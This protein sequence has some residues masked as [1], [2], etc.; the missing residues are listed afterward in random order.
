M[1]E[2]EFS[3]FVSNHQVVLLD[4]GWGHQLL[5]YGTPC[6]DYLNIV[7]P[8]AVKKIAES[9]LRAGSAIIGTN[10][11]GANRIRLSDLDLD[12]HAREINRRG[13]DIS[14][15]AAAGK[16]LVAGTI[17]PAVSVWNISLSNRLYDCFAE[18]AMFLSDAGVDLLCLETMQDIRQLEIALVASY[19]ACGLPVLC[20]VSPPRGERE[21]RSG[22]V[23]A[24]CEFAVRHCVVAFGV[25]CGES[26]DD[27]LPFIEPLRSV[28]PETPILFKPSAGV[29]E[30]IDGQWRYPIKPEP[31]AQYIR[32]AVNAGAK[33]VGGCCGT[34]ASYIEETRTILNDIN[35]EES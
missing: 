19:E 13:A 29:P 9:F 7:N 30:K 11:F 31:F 35:P 14:L 21:S 22:L 26:A 32:E 3:R 23:I 34:D 4:G 16:A 27:L 12:K 18:Q 2:A 20:S 6:P 24:C 33:L 17:G 28:F 25:N 10:T 15:N 1:N 5:Q 8:A